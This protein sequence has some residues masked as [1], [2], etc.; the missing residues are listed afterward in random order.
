MNVLRRHRI[1]AADVRRVIGHLRAHKKITENDI[2]SRPRLKKKKG[3]PDE[4]PIPWAHAELKGSWQDKDLKPGPNGANQLY[5]KEGDKWKLVVPEEQVEKY[6]RHSLLSKDSTMP[7]GRDSAYHHI[8][9]E[10]ATISRRRMYAFLEK[11]GILQVT[12]NIPNESKKGGIFLKKRG[13]LEMDLVEGRGIDLYKYF[14]ARGDWYWLAVVDV[15]TGYGIVALSR[16]KAAA[17]IAK[18]L[19]QVLDVMEHKLGTKATQISADHGREFFAEVRVLLKKRRIRIKQVPKGS[20]VEKFNQ[21]YQRNFYRLLRMRRGNFSELEK[22]ALKLTNNT[23]NK[24]LKMTPEEALSKPDAE[25]VGPYTH[26]REAHEKFKGK[27]PKVGDKCR[28]LIKMR[29]NIRPIL[30]I[31]SKARTYKS[32]HGRHFSKQVHKITRVLS[33][34]TDDEGNPTGPPSRY[35]VDGTWRHRDQILLVS[36]T[37]SETD[38]QIARRNA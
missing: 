3:L 26:G 16:T 38:A 25:L 33:Q 20:R 18:K 17:A 8:H 24:N 12:K 37:D 5:T 27:T 23:R 34:R 21:D 13:Y 30:K 2:I 32:Y 35:L 9:R 7:H 22:Q 1:L 31:G 6:M 28:Y 15:L 4:E 11:Q 14:G 19:D 10:T 36:G 29:K